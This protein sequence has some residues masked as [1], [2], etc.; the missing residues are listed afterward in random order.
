MWWDDLKFLSL[1]D[2][3]I[4]L[5][6]VVF[7]KLVGMLRRHRQLIYTLMESLFSSMFQK[8]GI[9][10]SNDM[11][12]TR[13]GRLLSGNFVKVV[14]KEQRRKSIVLVCSIRRGSP[15]RAYGL[16]LVILSIRINT[17]GGVIV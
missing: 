6:S 15:K 14:K 13:K 16:V 5:K 4:A 1:L 8:K 10:C 17:K 7:L 2:H 11:S 3:G 12:C 9:Y